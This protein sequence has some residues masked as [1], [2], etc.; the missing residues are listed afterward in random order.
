M[1]VELGAIFH[2]NLVTVLFELI[3]VSEKKTTYTIL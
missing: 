2:P 1:T 3:K